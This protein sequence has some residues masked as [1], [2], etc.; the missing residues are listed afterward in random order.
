MITEIKTHIF[1]D[2]PYGFE[3]I[4][5]YKV[6]FGEIELERVY[7]KIETNDEIKEGENT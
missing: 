7:F 2:Q 6:V 1:V 3:P 5:F 4:E